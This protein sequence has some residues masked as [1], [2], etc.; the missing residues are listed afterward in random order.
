MLTWTLETLHLDLKYTWKISRGATNTKINYVIKVSDGKFMGLGE[1]AG[2]TKTQATENIIPLAFDSLDLKQLKTS[3]D[4]AKLLI[5][6]PLRFALESALIHLNCKKQNVEV[7]QY[8][9]IPPPPTILPT[10][11]SLPIM[12]IDQIPDFISQHQVTR[13]SSC[14]IKVGQNLATESCRLVAKHFNGP[15]RIDANESFSSSHDVI[16]FLNSVRDL[17]IEFLEQPLPATEVDQ[18]IELKKHSPVMIFA[19]E[20]VQSLDLDQ[21]IQTQFH[22]VNIKLMKAGS[23]RQA[24]QQLQQAKDMGLKTMLGCMVETSL[25]IH[26]ALQLSS[27]ADHL[28]LDGFLFF[29]NDPYNLVTEK[30]GELFF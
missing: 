29:K 12:E 16:E 3:N 26:S 4:I 10:S 23:Y 9:K 24:L 17:N 7:W 6:E 11:F 14:K 13:F 1:V 28:D 21:K 19:D 18:Y 25:G 5:P 8:L 2:I 15:L 30:N 22:G 20:S 27:Q